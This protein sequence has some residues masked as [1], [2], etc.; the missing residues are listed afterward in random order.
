MLCA[1][2]FSL[3]P[4]AALFLVAFFFGSFFG[5]P[6]FFG[7]WI[8]FRTI[9]PP[10]KLCM[11]FGSHRHTTVSATIFFAGFFLRFSFGRRF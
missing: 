4:L 11:P 5:K 3:V 1:P 8:F 6:L 2:V 10:F 7:E 9:S